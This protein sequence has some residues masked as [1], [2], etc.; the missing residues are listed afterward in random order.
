VV[1][2]R[3][4]AVLLIHY[5]SCLPRTALCALSTPIACLIPSSLPHYHRLCA[6]ARACTSIQHFARLWHHLPTYLHLLL[7]HLNYSS[8]V[9]TAGR[10]FSWHYRA[11]GYNMCCAILFAF[12]LGA[13]PRCHDS[14]SLRLC[15][16]STVSP[17]WFI[18]GHARLAFKLWQPVNAVTTHYLFS[19]IISLNHT[20]ITRTGGMRPYAGDALA[21]CNCPKT[22]RAVGVSRGQAADS[23]PLPPRTCG[24]C[25]T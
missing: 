13:Y 19:A 10:C 23:V 3:L 20:P 24:T 17:P 22:P 8:M 21:V 2:P 12:L 6:L 11:R 1:A 14:R 9:A 18:H 7:F 5:H 25:G 4:L 16:L 15:D